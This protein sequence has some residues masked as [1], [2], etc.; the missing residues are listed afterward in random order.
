MFTHKQ[1]RKQRIEKFLFEVEQVEKT[2][3]KH[4]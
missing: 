2:M 4:T 3:H 1:K